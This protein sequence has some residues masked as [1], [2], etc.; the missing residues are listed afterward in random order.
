M[1]DIDGVILKGLGK[2][3]IMLGNSVKLMKK[4]L[5]PLDKQTPSLPF[6]FL[7]NGGTTTEQSKIDKMNEC[8]KLNPENG[9]SVKIEQMIMSHTVFQ[10]ESIQKKYKNKTVLIDCSTDD[11]VK[12][13]AEGYGFKN[14]ITLL[15]LMALYP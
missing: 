2:T 13:I 10:D 5:S 11:R 4:L 6:I 8:L 15:E 1:C 3:P 14:Y 7:T 12:P 9:P